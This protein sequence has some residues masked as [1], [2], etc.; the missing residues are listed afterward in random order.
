MIEETVDQ[1]LTK[2]EKKRLQAVKALKYISVCLNIF[3]LALSFIIAGGFSRKPSLFLSI[4]VYITTFLAL[5]SLKRY[6]MKKFNLKYS[7]MDQ[8]SNSNSNGIS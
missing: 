7:D 6:W 4:S 2:R 5:Y 8:S 3:I 1:K